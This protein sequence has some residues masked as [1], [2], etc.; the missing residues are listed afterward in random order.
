MP[1]LTLLT[2]EGN[3]HKSAGLNWGLS[4]RAHVRKNDAYIPIHIGTIRK[5]LDFFNSRTNISNTILTFRWDD[6]TVM[7]GRFE[8]TLPDSRTGLIY[9]KQI[10]SY[11]HKDILGEYLRRR[12]G[13]VS[14][15]RVTLDDLHRYGRTDIDITYINGTTYN[16]N[17]N[18]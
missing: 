16:L 12:L 3:V 10:A 2:S 11:P 13:V 18:V 7:Q 6:G 17:F 9:P 5:N 15:A 8:G 4:S 1:K 14:M